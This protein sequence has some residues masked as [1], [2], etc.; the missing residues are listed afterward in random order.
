MSKIIIVESPSKSKTIEGYLGADFKVL[1]SKGHLRDLAKSG[2]GG[3]GIDVENDFAPKY[4]AIK[5]KKDLIKSLQKECKGKEV[6]LATDPDREGEAISWHLAQIL[7]LDLNSENRIVFNEITK[8]AVIK[9]MEN[10]RKIDESLVSSQETRR[11]LDRIIGFRLSKLLQKKIQSKSAGRVQSVALKLI[12]DLEKIIN[13]FIPEEYW[14]ITAMFDGFK[15]DLASYK[16]KKIVIKNEE[17]KNKVLSELGDSYLVES[18]K[19]KDNIRKPK[20]PYITSTLQQDAANKLYFNSSKTM[21][22]AQKLYE[23]KKIGSEIVGLIT[24]MRT[25]S[26]RISE[27]FVSDTK[28]CI[29]KHYGKEYLGNSVF[30]N[31]KNSQ[32][33]HEAIRPSSLLRTPQSIEKHLTSDEYKLYELIFNRT[34]ASFMAPAI[35][36]INNISITN[37]Q[38]EFRVKDNHLVFPGFLKMYPEQI[39]E[40]TLPKI[41]LNELLS[42]VELMSKQNFTNPPARYNEAQLIKDMEELGIGRPSTY[43]QTMMTLKLRNY[44]VLKEKRFF[45]TEQGILTSEKLDEYFNT[46]INVEYTAHMEKTLDEIAN[47][48]LPKTD[49]IKNF[50]NAFQPLVDK[51]MENMEQR[52]LVQTGEECPECGSPL[53]VRRGRYGEFVSCSAFPKCK[54][55]KKSETASKVIDT[56]VICPKCGKGHLVI[57]TAKKGR[58]TGKKF[59]ACGDFPKCKNIIPYTIL[60][61]KCPKCGNLLI[62][63]PEGK[64]CIDEK[65]NL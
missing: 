5:D 50:Y 54:Y 36:K 17:E 47:S 61:E 4:V 13:K 2:I 57:R 42:L 32:D 62:D 65:C 14:T 29:L 63:T 49:V 44:V 27:S 24:Y 25:D 23:G 7:D 6:Y 8:Q 60:E 30:K 58:N 21:K 15:A 11:M 37:N 59:Y 19:E 43:S 64:K 56:N 35:F 52:A 33:A 3:L 9:A 18:I 31:K 48:K 20:P 26:T 53:V 34:V 38:Y 12:V 1:S 16:G 39:K 46:I 55:I 28:Q 51:A 45:P 22:I 10:P 41:T 40:I